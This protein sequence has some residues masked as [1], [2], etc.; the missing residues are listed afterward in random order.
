MNTARSTCTTVPG[1][2]VINTK[3]DVFQ[4]WSVGLGIGW[5][6]EGGKSRSIDVAFDRG[7]DANGLAMGFTLEF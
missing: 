7:G 5:L 4:I 1:R 6:T 2:M 3:G